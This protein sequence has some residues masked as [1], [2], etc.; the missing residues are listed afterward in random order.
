MRAKLSISA[1]LVLSAASLSCG[2]NGDDTCINCPAPVTQVFEG[3]IA[4]NDG[5]ETGTILLNL[6]DDG[7][8]SG[9]FNLG[10]ATVTFA[11]VGTAGNTVT[12]SGGGY[13][14]TGT[15]SGI[16]ID[17]SYSGGPGGLMAAAEKETTSTTL[18]PFCAAHDA[19]G[20]VAGIFAFVLNATTNA[21]RGVWTSGTGAGAAFK[22]I[23]SGFAGDDQAV[24]SGHPGIVTILP[25][26]Q[27]GTVGGFYDLDSGEAG[28]MSGPVCP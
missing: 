16:F 26:L 20:G 25:D 11:T 18:V 13:T 12:A 9:G 4:G 22:G 27:N 3:V 17:G 28:T 14:F 8:G 1:I 2:E 6:E 5:I 23:I 10:G 21:V 15:V 7:T 24:M 19:G